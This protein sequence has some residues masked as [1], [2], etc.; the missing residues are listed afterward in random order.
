MRDISNVDACDLTIVVPSV[1]L[2]I[3][4]LHAVMA[5]RGA[6]PEAFVFTLHLHHVCLISDDA[7][8]SDQGCHI[9]N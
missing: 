6:S 9:S 3:Y 5:R 1:P 7:Y 2:G 4:P 8:A